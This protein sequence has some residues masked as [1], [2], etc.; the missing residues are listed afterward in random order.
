VHDIAIITRFHYP[1]KSAEFDW[2]FG[3]YRDYI[4][5]CLIEQEDKDFDIAIWCEPWHEEQFLALSDKI[6]TFQATYTPGYHAAHVSSGIFTDL[7]EWENV[8]GLPEYK[9]QAGLDSDDIV[10]PEYI[11]IIRSLCVGDET[12]L[13]SFQ[14]VLLNASTGKLAPMR[15]YTTEETSAFFALY[16]PGNTHYR[17]AYCEGHVNLW[18]IVDKVVLVQQGHC[19]AVSHGHND[20]THWSLL[21]RII[22]QNEWPWARLIN[23]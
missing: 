19:C 10:G 4:L 13:V 3:F 20:S 2:R 16:N 9:I 8:S 11:K 21:A 18:K 14:P 6:R 17:F 23:R 15:Q 7:T 22:L 12:I 5:P 1:K